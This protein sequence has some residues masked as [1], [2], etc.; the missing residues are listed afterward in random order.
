MVGIFVSGGSKVFAKGATITGNGDGGVIV[1]GDSY[2]D[3]DGANVSDNFG[4]GV[5]VDN[6]EVSAVN[7]IISNNGVEQIYNELNI[8]SSSVNESQLE[9]IID[10]AINKQCDISKKDEILNVLSNTAIF[11]G[12]ASAEPIIAAVSVVLSCS[13][14]TL[15]HYK[16]IFKS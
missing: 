6:S 1:E 14:A 15:Q 5:S 7:A 8:D 9:Y 16:S 2:V 13:L 10:Q 4:H 12:I 3:L 11:A